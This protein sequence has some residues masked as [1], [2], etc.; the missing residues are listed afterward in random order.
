[1]SEFWQCGPTGTA[2]VS[3]WTM[4]SPLCLL[5]YIIITEM[6][7]EV[8]STN[9]VAARRKVRGQLDSGD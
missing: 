2:T 6:T 4:M 3:G 5:S 7:D 8:A 1:M 9:R